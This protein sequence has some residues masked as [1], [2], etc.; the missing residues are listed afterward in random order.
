MQALVGCKSFLK[1]RTVLSVCDY[2]AYKT[3]GPSTIPGTFSEACKSASSCQMAP[4]ILFFNDKKWKSFSSS[5]LD[6]CADK[7]VS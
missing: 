7:S 6:F 3:F 5:S 1:K 2:V 4:F